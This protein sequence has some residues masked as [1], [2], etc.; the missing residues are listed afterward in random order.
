MRV[1]PASLPTALLQIRRGG[2]ARRRC[3]DDGGRGGSTAATTGGVLPPLRG[4]ERGLPRGTSTEGG[5]DLCA[6]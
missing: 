4:R 5:R 2:D 3:R 6:S 1:R